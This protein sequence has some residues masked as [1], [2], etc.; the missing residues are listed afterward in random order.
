MHPSYK[1]HAKPALRAVGITLVLVFLSAVLLQLPNGFADPQARVL[2]IVQL[3]GLTPLLL[4][5]LLCLVLALA[6]H[7]QSLPRHTGE[8]M[9]SRRDGLLLRLRPV[10]LVLASLYLAIIPFTLVSVITI[11]GRGVMALEKQVG[12]VRTQQAKLRQELRNNPGTMPSPELLKR[13]PS[14]APAGTEPRPIAFY[15]ER[16]NQAELD[17]RQGFERKRRSAD[18]DLTRRYLAIMISSILYATVFHYLW[19]YWPSYP[20]VIATPNYKEAGR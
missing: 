3:L 9:P 5:G 4:I 19:R 16:L 6:E 8:A 13:Y 11:R 14:L 20:K 1:N 2:W 15:L 7:W 12:D 10:V 17:L 18:S